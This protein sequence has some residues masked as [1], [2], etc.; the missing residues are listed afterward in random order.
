MVESSQA[1]VIARGGMTVLLT[2]VT[3][4]LVNVAPTVKIFLFSLS[5][6]FLS[7]M[8]IEDGLRA[9]FFTFLAAALLGLIILPNKLLI[10]PYFLYF[11]YYGILK[12]IFER[13]GSLLQ[14]WFFKLL[15]FN[16]A[17][18]AFYII[19]SFLLYLPFE[20]KLPV[21][22]ILLLAQ[23]YFFIYDYCYTL[24][25]AYYYRYRQAINK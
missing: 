5:T 12:S 8:V 24:F 2:V 10:L 1:R 20:S 22:L 23:V 16:L 7:V 14:E 18:L 3:L 6:V 4:Y 11:G 13:R 9:A 17:L 19:G 25:I 15:S 21:I